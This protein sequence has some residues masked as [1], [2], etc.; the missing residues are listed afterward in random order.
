M[1]KSH[2]FMI[3]LALSDLEFMQNRIIVE[4]VM[5]SAQ[6]WNLVICAICFFVSAILVRFCFVMRRMDLG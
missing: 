2:E 3:L 5:I 6:S 1:V 4:S